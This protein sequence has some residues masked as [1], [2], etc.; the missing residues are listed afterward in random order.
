MA[1][2]RRGVFVALDLCGIVSL[3]GKRTGELEDRKVL[4]DHASTKIGTYKTGLLLDQDLN[5]GL[6]LRGLLRSTYSLTD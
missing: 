3:A 2:F 1:I 5:N 4:T 6:V